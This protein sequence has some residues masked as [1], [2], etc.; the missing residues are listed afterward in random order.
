MTSVIADHK[1]CI[2][3]EAIVTHMHEKSNIIQLLHSAT[4]NTIVYSTAMIDAASE[5]NRN[6]NHS[7]I[8]DVQ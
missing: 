8:F 7:A 6:I 2:R 4:Y 1:Y 3:W 5:G